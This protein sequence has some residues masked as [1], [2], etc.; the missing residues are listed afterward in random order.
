MTKCK[1][2]GC[3]YDAD[4]KG[5]CWL[6]YKALENRGFFKKSKVNDNCNNNIDSYLKHFDLKD[7][8]RHKGCY[9]K[10]VMLGYCQYH[11]SLILAKRERRQKELEKQNAKNELK[12]LK[13][14]EICK[15]E[16]CNEEVYAKKLCMQHYD[17]WRNGLLVNQETICNYPDCKRPA[18]SKG[19]C[20]KHYQRMR[21]YN[22]QDYKF[23]KYDSL[24]KKLLNERGENNQCIITN[25]NRKCKKGKDFCTEHYKEV[26]PY[27]NTKLLD[28]ILDK[29]LSRT[30]N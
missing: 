24:Y 3:V 19:Y 27:L 16:G 28:T 21:T 30:N 23:V 22:M 5:Y 8:C 20:S 14:K 1:I 18:V 11:F 25:C 13:S 29:I 7:K 10:A 4:C 17:D 6:H 15:V 2:D 9:G 26:K 12:K